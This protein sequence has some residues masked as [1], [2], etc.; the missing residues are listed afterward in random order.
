LSLPI[1]PIVLTS[2]S[3]RRAIQSLSDMQAVLPIRYNALVADRESI[4]E[5]ANG[6]DTDILS[7]AVMA[8]LPW[9]FTQ[10]RPLSTS[11]FISEAKRRGFDFNLPILRELY[12][13]RLVEPFLYVSP[14]QVGPI[15][16]PVT[17]EPFSGSSSLIALRH[18]RDCGR[19][20]DLAEL[21]FR[22]R[23]RFERKE[24]DHWDWWNGLFYSRF[25]LLVLP[26]LRSVLDGRRY[27]RRRGQIVSWLPKPHQLVLG[28]I[29]NFR[30]FAVAA[31]ALEAAYL[32]KLD[33]EWLQLVNTDEREW[34]RYRDGFDPVAMS[35]RLGYSAERAR[36]D[37]EWLLLRASHLDPV[38]RSWSQLMRR[39]PRKSWKDLKNDALL[40]M[41]YREA[42]E[43]LLLFYEDLAGRGQA[44][45]LPT[46]FG[47][48]WHPLHERLSYRK[49]TLDQNLMELGVSPHPRVV[50]AIEGDTEQVHA[51]L[52]WK[53]LGY[54]EAP[55]LM[56]LLHLGGADRQ[57]QKL[58][59]LAAA[60]LVGGEI[61]GPE[62][63]WLIKPPTRLFVAVDP[64]GQFAPEK[65]RNTRAKIMREIKDVL[66]AQ[67]V[68][69]A[70][71]SELDE[72]VTI[73]TWSASCY[74][75]AHFTDDELADGIMAVHTTINGLT[76]D[77]L[78]GRL[79]AERR[80]RKDIKEVWSLWDYKP[81]KVELARALWPTLERKIQQR[82]ADGTS[83]V[84]EIAEV[85]YE[86]Y[87]IAQ[88]W[89]YQAFVL[90]AG[91]E[92][93]PD[94]AS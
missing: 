61:G 31:T 60:P 66:Q 25:Q 82:L 12:R 88:R 29:A 49:D 5:T 36:Q 76:R 21:P 30:R 7:S 74:E 72:L 69:N 51:P 10:G 64:E 93:P 32:P 75:F 59:A 90:G 48:S 46:D 41:D 13:H 68:T 79:A 43:L 55:E 50:L 83:P 20:C 34:R 80:R 19:L 42:A 65:V 16:A 70:N 44:E 37:A 92:E 1:Y 58:A 40:A 22:P 35:Q 45:P 67:G 86:A 81:S 87:M 23:L 27:G 91:P 77:E 94:P 52:V 73:H 6:A 62:G 57:L 38:G 71:P 3:F 63:W 56:R 15:P 33:P 84:P 53:A 11:D 4:I 54:P 28:R 18:A 17:G 9:A 26:E 47:M 78:I 24:G 89:R 39:A 2:R 8:G 85:V 14:R